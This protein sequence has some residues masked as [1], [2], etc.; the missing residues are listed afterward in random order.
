MNKIGF[1]GAGNVSK[2]IITGMAKTNSNSI[3]YMSIPNQ[4]NPRKN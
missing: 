1:I 2:A 3:E 4:M